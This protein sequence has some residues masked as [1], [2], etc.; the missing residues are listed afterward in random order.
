MKA[1]ATI[2]STFSVQTAGFVVGGDMHGSL[3]DDSK[4]EVN[5]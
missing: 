3:S 4:T 2:G 5:A 1:S